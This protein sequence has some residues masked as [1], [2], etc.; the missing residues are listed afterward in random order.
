MSW[1]S[2]LLAWL[3]R[4]L[5]RLAESLG[6]HE[7]RNIVSPSDP[8]PPAEENPEINPVISAPR[9]S[10]EE[11][12]VQRVLIQEGHGPKPNYVP[13]PSARPSIDTPLRGTKIVAAYIGMG[14]EQQENLLFGWERGIWGFKRGSQPR[15]KVTEGDLIVIGSGFSAGAPRVNWDKWSKGTLRNV[16]I[17]R[18]KAPML[19]N[20]EP[21]WPNER[22]VPAGLRY[23]F[24]IKFDQIEVR[25]DVRLDGQELLSTILSEEL[26]RSAPRGSAFLCDAGELHS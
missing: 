14:Q 24:R 22:A 9:E 17:G 4:F 25:K 16:Y 12:L 11:K 15:G 13:P 10:S 20:D 6:R 23:V 3:G 8:V 18:I 7:R 5:T 19:E 26:R 1:L 21:F 2:N